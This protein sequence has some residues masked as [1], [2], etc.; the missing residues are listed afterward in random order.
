MLVSSPLLGQPDA[1]AIQTLDPSTRTDP[2]AGYTSHLLTTP[3][4]TAVAAGCTN[5]SGTGIAHPRPSFVAA[6]CTTF[7]TTLQFAWKSIR[8]WGTTPMGRTFESGRNKLSSKSSVMH[9]FGSIHAKTEAPRVLSCAP[10]AHNLHLRDNLRPCTA[11]SVLAGSACRLA[12]AN[13]QASL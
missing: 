8:Q 3:H 11:I 1:R 13:G 2:P 10:L 9:S 7:S 12:C 4:F 6:G 5:Q